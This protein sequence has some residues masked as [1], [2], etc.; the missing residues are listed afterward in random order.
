VIL[1]ALFGLLFGAVDCHVGLRAGSRFPSIPFSVLSISILRASA[2][3]PS[4]KTQ[5][6]ADHRLGRRI[7]RRRA[8]MFTIPR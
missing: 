5:H 1:G 3:P 4:S 7:A 8:V 2:V 6:R